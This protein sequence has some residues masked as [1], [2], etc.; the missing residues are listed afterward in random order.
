MN[1]RRIESPESRM[2]KIARPASP[3]LVHKTCYSCLLSLARRSQ[4]T[5]QKFLGVLT[6]SK[7]F[8]GNSKARNSQ[9]ERPEGTC[10]P[11]RPPIA[12]LLCR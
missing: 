1:S 2:K 8:S 9:R 7:Q 11:R 6:Q 3:G 4:Q 5:S 10:R 12:R